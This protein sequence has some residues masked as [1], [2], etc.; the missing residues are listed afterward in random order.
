MQST[1]RRADSVVL[2]PDLLTC[3]RDEGSTTGQQTLRHLGV[4]GPGFTSPEH[5]DYGHFWTGMYSAV[6]G[7]QTS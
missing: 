5:P 7:A 1:A 6:L 4:V 3:S 2:A